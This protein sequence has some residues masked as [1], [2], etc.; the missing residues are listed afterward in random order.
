M[1]AHWRILRGM[2]RGQFV[3]LMSETLQQCIGRNRMIPNGRAR[4]C[5]RELKIIPF[6]GYLMRRMARDRIV[7]DAPLF[8]SVEIVEQQPALSTT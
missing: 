7:D 5:T 6:A 1:F 3:P 4:F 8:A 2:L